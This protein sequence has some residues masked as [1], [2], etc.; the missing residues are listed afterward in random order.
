MKELK[1]IKEIKYKVIKEFNDIYFNII[2]N[3]GEVIDITEERAK[4]IN[5]KTIHV[6]LVKDNKEKE[7]K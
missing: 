2:R 7:E 3:K 6:E 4:E 5:K 1:D